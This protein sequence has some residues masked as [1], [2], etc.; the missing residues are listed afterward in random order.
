LAFAAL[1]MDAHER[2]WQIGDFKFD[3]LAVTHALCDLVIVVDL[4]DV[5]DDA[6]HFK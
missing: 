2:V 4:Q 3:R 6:K 5:F 1:G